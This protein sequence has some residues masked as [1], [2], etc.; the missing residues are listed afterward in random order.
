MYI[1]VCMYLFIY[2]GMYMYMYMYPE[3]LK[4]SFNPVY[5]APCLETTLQE[6]EG[7]PGTCSTGYHLAAALHS[8]HLPYV[9][10][11]VVLAYPG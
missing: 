8:L 6:D 1:D 7:T 4:K 2:Y 3:L 11:G 9:L 5:Y 10:S